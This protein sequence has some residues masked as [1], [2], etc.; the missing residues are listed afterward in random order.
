MLNQILKLTRP[1][2]ILDLETT[3]LNPDLERIVQIAI[4]KH[5]PDQEPIAWSTLVNPGIPIKNS[6]LHRV[7]D[8]RVAAHPPFSH[9]AKH[10]APKLENVDIGG[11]NVGFDIGFLT[12]E[13]RRAGVKMDDGRPWE[14]TGHIVDT[15]MI[16]RL[17]IPHT[18]SNL[19]KRFVD[20][21][22]IPIQANGISEAH[23]AGNDVR[24]TTDVLC[25]QL[26]EFS[27]L[28]RT[29][30]ELS[31]FCFKKKDGIDKQGKFIWI[32][33]KPCINFGKHRG[34]PIQNVDK[35]YL[36]WM[37]NTPNFPDDAVLIAGDALKGIYPTK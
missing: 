8:E 37:I 23:D 33:D 20:P 19:Y 18:L 14:F 7:T 21:A 10:L 27:E 16:A 22:G 32:D 12:A 17:M 36:I 29:V 1:L 4:T 9:W 13:M 6:G 31:E 3:G 28:P 30:A 35:G 5:Y 11:Q 34:T 2:A 25:G 26:K 15:L 24:Y